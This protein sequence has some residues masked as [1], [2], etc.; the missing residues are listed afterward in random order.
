MLGI[1]RKRLSSGVAAFDREASVPYQLFMLTLCIYAIGAL[2]A[3]TL[4][5][6]DPDVSVIIDYADLA[7]CFVF[8]LDFLLCV[9]KAKGSRWRYFLTWG[10]L[11]LLSSVPALDV[12]RWGR[13]AR[14]FR[15][16]RVLRGLR[17]SQIVAGL[18]MKHRAQSTVL[19]SALAALILTVTC[20]V[21]ILRFEDGQDSNIRTGG[22]AIWWAFATITTVGYGDRY[23][24]TAEGRVVAAI[25]MTAGVGLS[26]TVAA[27][28]AAWFLQPS[29][30]EE[31]KEDKAL[32]RELALLRASVDRLNPKH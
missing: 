20:S 19:V 25:L 24:V 21:A 22:D 12:A 10:W 27:F 30:R 26:S 7:V 6:V 4:G 9:Y 13:L 3:E 11:D 15:I 14:V 28:L 1:V 8:F 23:P 2:A 18:V 5:A 31:D 16:F 29:R 32:Q 17:M